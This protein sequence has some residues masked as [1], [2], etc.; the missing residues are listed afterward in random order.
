MSRIFWDNKEIPQPAGSHIDR[1]DGRVFI[2]LDE[3]KPVRQSRKVTIGHATSETMMHPNTMYRQLFPELWEKYYGEAGVK[4]HVRRFGLYAL[5]LGA[6]WESGLYPLLT[7]AYGPRTSNLV[8][9][10]AMYS[11]AHH[12]NVAQTFGER[13]ADE[14]LFSERLPGENRLSEMFSAGLDE[15]STF[16]FRDAWLARC[17]ENGLSSVW[18]SI[19]GSN[20]DCSVS[21]SELVEHG[22][23]KSRLDTGL[24]S[25]MYAVDTESGMPVTYLV[26]NGGKVDVKAINGMVAYLKGHG[27]SVAGVILDRAFCA[28][29]V[30]AMLGRE[31]YEYVVMLKSN[32]RGHQEMMEEHG[33]DVRWNV[34]HLAG[35]GGL[36]GVSS[37]KKLFKNH[38]LVAN[39][40]LFFDAG[41][42][43]ER[44]ITLMDK[45][46]VAVAD[47]RAA[48][49]S[50]RAPSVPAALARYVSVVED[51]GEWRVELVPDE[52]QKAVDAKG[53]ATIASSIA[54]TPAEANRI[55]HLRD[56]SEKQYMFMKTQLGSAVVR[57]HS[58]EGIMGKFAACFAAAILRS[59]ILNACRARKMVPNKMLLEMD[60]LILLLNGNDLYS[61]IHDESDRQ[62]ALLAAFG[63]QPADLDVIAGEFNSREGNPVH[64]QIRIRPE[65]GGQ[66]R[67]RPGRP[68]GTARKRAIAGTDGEKPKRGR[69]RP[70]GSLNRKT[71]ERLKAQTGQTT[72]EK[73]GRGRPKGSRNKPKIAP[74]PKRGRGRPKGSKNKPKPTQPRP[75]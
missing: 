47:A 3:G 9:D 35:E 37:R 52:L 15:E 55:Y 67:R 28:H 32:T 75:K 59:L 73:R 31:G 43:A 51:N 5:A 16:R 36:F 12:S 50:G 30:L 57:V 11:M 64:S 1:T 33:A 6:G 48:L 72:K 22:K 70:K 66:G 63:I 21:D 61:A 68:K 8:M 27:V 34:R 56:A 65:R 19:D 2:Y 40:T 14:V 24:V 49:E 62:K 46:L 69:G 60:R 10:Y 29:D 7:E 38:P 42:G 53:Y 39:T 17:V 44:S 45:V 18:L 13:M 71:I 25:Y 4:R 54:L 58:T 74:V 26:Y 20:S 23:A 41:N